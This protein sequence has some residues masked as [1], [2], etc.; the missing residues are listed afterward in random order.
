MSKSLGN[1]VQPLEMQARYG[2]DAFRYFLLREIPWDSDGNFTWDRFTDV[3]TAELADGLGNLASRSLAML[4]K[5]RDGVVPAA[6]PTSLDQAGA[7]A[8]EAYEAAMKCN[9]LR[10]AADA[11][12]RIVTAAN[13]YIVQTA[14]WVLAKGGKDAEL[15]AALASLARCL[16][17]MAVLASPLMP[18]KAE[19]LWGVLG[20]P[21][22]A[23]ALAE[24]LPAP[25]PDRARTQKRTGSSPLNQPQLLTWHTGAAHDP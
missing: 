12:W 24:S 10:G 1:V 6:E 14:P 19:E 16:Y 17:R 9:D 18:G 25:P 13:Q 2:R 4:A 7:E 20:Q 21:G 11:A 3:Y 15:D 23:A 5:Y 8:I 22:E